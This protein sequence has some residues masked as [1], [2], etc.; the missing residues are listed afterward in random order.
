MAFRKLTQSLDARLTDILNE[1]EGLPIGAAFKD[2]AVELAGTAAFA[3]SIDYGEALRAH[4][5]V[6]ERC[7][8]D[9]VALTD[10]GYLKPADV[11][12][13]AT[14]LPTMDDW[15][16]PVTREV[17]AKPALYFREYLKDIG[18]LRKYKGT[19]R[20]TKAGK[21]G[22]DSPSYLWHHL[23]A[24][25][26]PTA[27]AFVEMTGVVVLVHM[28]TT[29]GRIDVDAVARTM[30][31]LGWSAS[32]GSVVEQRDVYPV[33]NDLWAALGNV[34]TSGMEKYPLDRRLSPEAVALAR[35][36]LFV[37]VPEPAA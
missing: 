16:F 2:R 3:E 23:A 6:L 17:H 33:W 18:L 20:A 32:D 26:V 5:W 27:P 35:D 30:T 4:R 29:D 7:A 12:E 25:L 21:A 8:G 34:G 19:L 36:A 15:I 22:L 31:A 9:G 1:L 14:V 37:E 13:L 11:K 24:T 28:A 10:A